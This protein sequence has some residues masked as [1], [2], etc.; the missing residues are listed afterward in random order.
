[1]VLTDWNMSEMD[2]LTF[3]KEIKKS[4]LYSYHANHYNNNRRSKKR[5][6]RGFEKW[7]K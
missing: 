7:R 6:R 4:L 1:M 2:G 5:R 3:V